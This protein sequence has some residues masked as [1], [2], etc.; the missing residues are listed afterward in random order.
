MTDDEIHEYEDID[1]ES[2]AEDANDKIEEL[3]SKV[4]ELETEVEELKTG[5][6]TSH[7]DT[8][9]GTL[10]SFGACLA[11]ILSWHSFHAVLWALLAGI[12]SWLYVIYYV[13]ANWPQVR[14]L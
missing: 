11:M 8:S 7:G 12:F 4:E 6:Q 10:Y 5:D 14:L 3:E 2:D 13:I 9:G 1:H